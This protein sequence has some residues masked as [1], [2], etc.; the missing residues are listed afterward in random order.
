MASTFL[1]STCCR[2]QNRLYL[3]KDCS[4]SEPQLA[5]QPTAFYVTDF[6]PMLG[7]P[8]LTD[9]STSLAHCP[10][11]RLTFPCLNSIYAWPATPE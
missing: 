9:F 5:A 10:P 11:N 3:E 6:K 1:E 8:S 4:G 2:L 7:W